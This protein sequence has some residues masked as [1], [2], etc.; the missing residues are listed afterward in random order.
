MGRAR[1]SFPNFPSACPSQGKG[2][3]HFTRLCSATGRRGASRARAC[4]W[5]RSR[6]CP[7]SRTRGRSRASSPPRARRRS[8]PSSTRAAAREPT[9]PAKLQTSRSRRRRFGRCSDASFFLG[10]FVTE[11]V[12]TVKRYLSRVAS[13]PCAGAPRRARARRR[14][15]EVEPGHGA[16][17]AAHGGAPRRRRAQAPGLLGAARGRGRHV[18]AARA[19]AEPGRARRD[20]QADPADGQD[21]GPPRRGRIPGQ[22]R[23]PPA[24]RRATRAPGDARALGEDFV[25]RARGSSRDRED[26][27]RGPAEPLRVPQ[28]RRRRAPRRLRV[29]AHGVRE[30]PRRREAHLAH[31]AEP[32]TGAHL[33]RLRAR[34]FS[35]RFGCFLDERPSFGAVS[36]R[37]RLF[38]WNARA[39]NPRGSDVESPF[40]QARR[41][42]GSS[43]TRSTA[44]TPTAGP[45]ATRPTTSSRRS[46][47]RRRGRRRR[48]PRPRPR[49]RRP[50][51]GRPPAPRPRRRARGPSPTG[52][53]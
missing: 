1:K 44:R 23:G 8:S 19:A 15:G 16:R 50:R 10:E 34:S 49:P 6:S 51:S 4:S 47:A 39:R 9:G 40:S 43:R 45:S 5:R 18:G 26:A 14:R 17:R 41:S 37:R 35:T 29:P 21:H 53:C 7:S 25:A 52:A 13:F 20:A 42:A 28:P 11:D 46:G 30:R 48:R 27:R 36:R 38:F 3:A 22:V 12:E 32:R 31:G 24:R 33:Q 2:A